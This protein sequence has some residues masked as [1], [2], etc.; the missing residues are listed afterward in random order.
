M[1]IAVHGDLRG[2]EVGTERR[3]LPHDDA[4]AR[5]PRGE[6]A[7]LDEGRDTVVLD[8]GE[9]AVVHAAP[10]IVAQRGRDGGGPPPEQMGEEV[11][12]MDGVGLRDAD[13]RAR[14]LEAGEAPGRV[15]HRPD[16]AAGKLR[17]EDGGDR[18][19]AEDVPHLEDAPRGAHD[20]RQLPPVGEGEGE[21]LLDKTVPPGLEA[22][23]GQR[24]VGV[25]GRDQI[26]GVHMGQRLAEVLH[27]SRRL[28]AGLHREGPPLGREI[29]HPQLDAE[30]LEHAQVLLAPAPQPDQEQ[31]HGSSP[32][33]SSATS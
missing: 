33:R 14:P 17:L 18:V 7:R 1:A 13:I 11:E 20:P 22:G 26:H 5:G 23:P 28:H 27:R 15:A 6:V 32:A 25:G 21:R 4:V 24:E 31:L 19:E 2:A 8:R 3:L 29:G 30:L 16:G 10:Q 9:G 12:V